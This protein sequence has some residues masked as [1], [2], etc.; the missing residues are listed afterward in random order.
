M[1]IGIVTTWFER[2]AAYVS[3]QYA[4]ALAKKHEVFIYARG[5]E[6]TGKSDPNW[7]KSNVWW[8]RRLY[9]P[10][11]TMIYLPDFRRWIE[12]TGVEVILF[13]EQISLAP[14]IEASKLGVK[15]VAYIDYYRQDTIPLFGLYDSLLC[16]T[17]RH[18][19]AFAWHPGAHY[20]PWGTDTDL[21]PCATRPERPLT[22]FH[23]AGMDPYRKGTDF[24]VKALDL[25]APKLEFKALIHSQ[26]PLDSW[27]DA[28]ARA[29]LKRLVDAKR[30]TICEKSVPA[31]GLYHEGDIYVYPSRLDGIGLT[32]AEALSSGLGCVTT[33]MPPMSEFVEPAWGALVPVTRQFARADGYYW[34]IAEVSAEALAATMEGFAKSVAGDLPGLRSRARA[35]AESH[36]CW[37]KNAEAIPG[38]FETVERH[39]ELFEK[40]LADY[41]KWYAAKGAIKRF[42]DNHPLTYHALAASLNSLKTLKGGMR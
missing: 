7:D 21:F 27:L 29:A 6:K 35:A 39:P 12:K 10:E 25:L 40:A 41:R 8:G 34:P 20:I 42:C 13:N 14:V 31:P 32:M 24:L 5:G 38:L 9:Y 23:S 11:L 3:R 37:K 36:Y 16:N 4:D 1:K 2:G 19:S 33:D 15:T 17:K 18:H 26:V 22:F 30:L 28:D